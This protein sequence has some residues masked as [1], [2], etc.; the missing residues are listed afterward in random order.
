MSTISD[1][2]N[3]S[4]GQAWLDACVELLSGKAVHQIAQDQSSVIVDR[5]SRELGGA[6]LCGDDD[7]K[8]LV[9][10]ESALRDKGV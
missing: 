6:T 2:D 5:P 7:A 4:F 1:T 3:F 8:G 10:V 9:F